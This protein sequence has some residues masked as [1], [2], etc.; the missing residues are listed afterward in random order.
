MF[1]ILSVMMVSHMS[2]FIKLH[3][4]NMYSFYMSFILLKIYL[5][6]EIELLKEKV[7]HP[8][9]IAN[10]WNTRTGKKGYILRS[11]PL[12]TKSE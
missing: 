1:N 5:E 4:F 3:S 12:S 11:K 7:N 8:K 6:N 2:K 10:K 9:H